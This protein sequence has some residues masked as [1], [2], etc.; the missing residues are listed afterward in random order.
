M[1]VTWI[2]DEYIL[3]SR[4]IYNEKLYNAIRQHGQCFLTRYKPF[5][6]QQDYGPDDLVNTPVVLYGTV[7]FVDKCKKPFVPG[8]FGVTSMMNCNYYYPQLPKEWLLNGRYI[9]LP[10]FEVVRSIDMLLEEMGGAIFIR[11]NSGKKTFTGFVLTYDNYQHELNCSQQ[12]T[13][14]MPETIC[15]LAKARGDIEG[16]FRFI[17][18][19]GRVIDGSE[20]RW[21]NILDIRH[22]YPAEC[23]QLAEKV[24]Q[25][26]WQP[27]S[28]Y[29]V[30]VALT[31][32]GPQIVELNSFSC[33]GLYACDPDIVVPA[34]NEIALGEWS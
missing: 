26:D 14:V 7:G 10:W 2:V 12:L 6:E 32:K 16:E 30:D 33:A 31:S 15:L 25:L 13:G 11:P 28:V 3:E 1:T 9:L 4:G 17:I 27:D 22:D 5:A 19:N 34:I 23:R 20:Y 21:D 24:G 18:G 29:C 8:A